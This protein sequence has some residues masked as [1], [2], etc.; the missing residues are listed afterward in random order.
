MPARTGQEYILGL[1]ERPKEVWIDGESVG[2]ITTHPAFRNGIK[3]VAGLYDM[4][5]D[6]ALLEEMTF[7][8][9]TSG[10]PVGLSFLVPE[11]IED[12]ERRRSMMERWAWASCGMMGRSPDFLN[13]IFAAWAGAGDYFAQDRPEF[14]KNVINYHKF[15]RENDLTLTHAL[16]NLQRRRSPGPADVL[17]DQVALTVVDENDAGMVVRGSR[18]LATLGPISDEI[19]IYPAASHRLHEADTRQSFSFSI[20]CDTPGVKFLCRE[21]LDLGRS[22]FNHPLGSRFEEMDSTVFFDDVLVPWERVFLMGDVEL[23]N[24]YGTGTHSN[25]HTGHQVLTRCVVK[26]EFILGL[27]D[28]IVETLGSGAIPHVQELVAEVITQRDLMRACLRAAE[29]DAVPNQWG[30]MS[31]AIG[32]IQAGRTIFGRTLYPRMI[33]IIQLLGTS[34][35]MA[36]PAEAD[37]D[38]ALAPEIDRYLSTDTSNA[39]E[40]ARLFH[41]AWDVACSSFSGRQVLYERMFGGNPVRNATMLFNNY[42]KEPFK[43][44]VRDF[45]ALED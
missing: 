31:P 2:D 20:P 1:K 30:V 37:F 27:A 8:S 42:N 6:P 15:I 12:L 29:A 40:R 17:S 16:V 43:Q 26:A 45:M 5:N 7:P 21:S 10:Q 9:P 34:S 11:T 3:S 36:L 33:E 44:R 38:T 13:V 24:N 25:S 18:V 14:K 19:A 4:Q 41:L 35:L 22:H 39:R 23:C 32:P 28:L